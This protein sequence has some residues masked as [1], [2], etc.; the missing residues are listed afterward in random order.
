MGLIKVL[1]VTKDE[2]RIQVSAVEEE[3]D[4]VEAQ[5]K[6]AVEEDYEASFPGVG[7]K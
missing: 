2:R 7:N 6:K 4:K 3:V 1:W 5:N